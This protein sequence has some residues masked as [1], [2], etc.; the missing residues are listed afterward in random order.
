MGVFA[1][2]VDVVT[3]VV[4]V[5]VPQEEMNEESTNNATSKKLKPNQMNFF[6]IYFSPFIFNYYYFSFSRLTSLGQYS[7]LL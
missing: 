3:G 6:R 1:A 7:Y 4:V 5:L 2:V